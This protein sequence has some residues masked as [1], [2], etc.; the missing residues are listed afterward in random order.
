MIDMAT[1][2]NAKAASGQL[3]PT[4]AVPYWHTKQ[5]CAGRGGK[6]AP[7]RIYR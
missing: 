4:A 3:P 6:K 2:Q 5:L 7:C 1:S